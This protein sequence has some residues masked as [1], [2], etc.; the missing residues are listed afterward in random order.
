MIAKQ[1]FNDSVVP[2]KP[3]DTGT[4][5]IAQMEECRLSH[6]PIVDEQALD[7]TRSEKVFNP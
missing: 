4:Y 2:L 6:L 7:V 5:A 3:T 1:L